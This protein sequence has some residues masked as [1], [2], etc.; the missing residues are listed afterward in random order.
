MIYSQDL[1][2]QLTQERESVR[3]VTLQKD[4]EV[5]ELHAR[6]DTTIADFARTRELLVGAETTRTHLQEKVSDLS[7]HY[8]GMEEKLA[9]YERRSNLGGIIASHS[10][11]VNPNLS[12]E[13]Q[14]EAEVADLRSAL[15]VAEV[16]LANARSHVQQFQEISQANE[17]ALSRLSTSFDEYKIATEAQVTRLEVLT[18]YTTSV[19]FTDV[20]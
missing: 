15:K 2:N 14:L 9:V 6:L 13:Q 3:H 17:A 4:I 7:K 11:E 10:H 19:R 5:K 20:I 16:D 18:T 8:Q 1:K 12:G